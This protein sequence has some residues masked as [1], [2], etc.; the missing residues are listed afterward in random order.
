MDF[1]SGLPIT[2]TKKDSMWVVMDQLTNSG[3]FIPIRTDFS[4]QK[5][6]KLYISEIVRLHGVPISIISDR[7]PRFTSQFWQ[8]LHEALGSHLDFSTTFHPQTDGERRILCPE[9][10][11]ETKDKV[12]VISDRLKVNSD[13]QKSYVDLKRK[14]IEY[15]VGDM[16]LK[17]VGLVTYQLE[18]PPELDR[19]H[20]IFHM[21]MLRRYPSDPTHIVPVEEIEVRPD[22]TF[23]EKPVQ[24]LDCDIKI[25]CRKSI[26]LVKWL[27]GNGLRLGSGVRFLV[28]AMGLFLLQVLAKS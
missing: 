5:L 10:V 1:I 17:R 18:R 21:S 4:L 25:L 19:I 12:H 14:D 20:D 3:H 2:L 23:E 9:L 24:I 27:G 7:D 8:K 15:F 13:R 22:L 6:A 11:L 16:I 26:P 28:V